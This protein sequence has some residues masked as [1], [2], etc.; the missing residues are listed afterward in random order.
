VS[1]PDDHDEMTLQLK[2]SSLLG[3]SEIVS[4]NQ[5][6]VKYFAQGMTSRHVF[7]PGH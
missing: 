2:K 3:L 4:Y 7:P 6:L 1:F 5:I